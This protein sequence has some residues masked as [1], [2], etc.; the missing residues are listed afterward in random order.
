MARPLAK[1]IAVKSALAQLWC[2]DG[3]ADET[4]K[5]EGSKAALAVWLRNESD[6]RRWVAVVAAGGRA[7][8]LPPDLIRN[9]NFFNA[10]DWRIP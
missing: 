7:A 1:D 8:D 5:L 6:C 9:K 10:H 4:R 2:L 3:L